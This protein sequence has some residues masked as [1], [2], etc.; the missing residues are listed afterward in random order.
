MRLKRIEPIAQRLQA[1]LKMSYN[2]KKKKTFV[3]TVKLSYFSL[4]P[5]NNLQ[6]LVYE[7]F[8]VIP[9]LD[10]RGVYCIQIT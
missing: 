5:G 10:K 7:R 6:E 4:K 9:F 3:V 1:T 8:K 2:A